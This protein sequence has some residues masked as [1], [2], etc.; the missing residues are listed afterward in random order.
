MTDAA[1]LG[2][3]RARTVAAM[4]L[5][6]V[7]PLLEPGE[8]AVAGTKAMPR[9]AAHEAILGAAGGVAG[10]TVAPALAGAGF[11]AGAQAG[12]GAGDEG[13]A[14][15]ADAGVDVGR[16]Q[17]ILLVV[18]DRRLLLCTTTWRGK[19]KEVAAALDRTAIQG[20]AMGE[21]KLFG[22]RMP[23]IVL[24]L[25]SGAEVGFGVAKVNRSDGE[26]VVAALTG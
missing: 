9:G 4:K 6:A 3:G 25:A 20:V 5:D 22:Q 8:R 21:A 17:Q 13:R 23:E 18:T 2:E 10:G 19:P 1:A 7:T 12:E 11:L 15:R 16:A 14:E 26:A 24:T